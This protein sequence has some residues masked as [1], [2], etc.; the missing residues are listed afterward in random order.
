MVALLVHMPEKW[1]ACEAGWIGRQC[2]VSH[3]ARD[4]GK[5]GIEHEAADWAIHL[6]AL[7]PEIDPALQASVTGELIELIFACVFGQELFEVVARC[8]EAGKDRALIETL[9]TVFGDPDG[10]E[11]VGSKQWWWD[12]LGSW[13]RRWGR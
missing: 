13:E 12:V 5:F 4:D 10:Q 2:A 6:A 8:K 11:R 7:A 1:I 9:T 3:P